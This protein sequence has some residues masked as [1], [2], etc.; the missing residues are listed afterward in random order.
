MANV[1]SGDINIENPEIISERRFLSEELSSRKLTII[2]FGSP[3]SPKTE[4]ESL[5][6]LICWVSPILFWGVEGRG[7]H[8]WEKR[9]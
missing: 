4:E 8:F 7:Q 3:K 1:L 6:L 9:R 5:I 2:P